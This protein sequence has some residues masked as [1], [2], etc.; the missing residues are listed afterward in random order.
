MLSQYG[1]RMMS[2]TFQDVTWDE[3]KALLIGLHPDTALGRVIA[4]RAEEDKEMLKSFT[5]EQLRIR[6]E[7]RNK[8]AKEVSE[9]EMAD[10]LEGFKQA[11][12]KMAGENH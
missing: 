7:Y 12:I 2:E 10:V 5:K 4:I 6:S 8:I 1:I 3:F 11:F 9:E